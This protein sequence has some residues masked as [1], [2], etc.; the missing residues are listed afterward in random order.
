MRRC[1]SPPKTGS[2]AS[3]I[4]ENFIKGYK[5]IEGVH[6]RLNALDK[7]GLITHPQ[8]GKWPGLKRYADA[9]SGNFPQNIILEPTGFT[10]YNKGKEY[11]GYATQKPPA[12]YEIFIKASSNEGDIVLDPFCGCGTTLVVSE[13]FNR[14]WVGIDIWDNAEKIVLGLFERHGLIAKSKRIGFS[15]VQQQLF[16]KD[17]TWTSNLP[18]RTDKGEEAVPFLKTK[19]K[20]DEPKGPKMTRAEMLEI[21]LKQHGSRCQGCNRQ[22][23]DPRYLELDH[24]APRS[25]GGINHISNRIL[26]CGPCNK[27]KSNKF[28]LSGLIKENKRLGYYKVYI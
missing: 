27:L 23:D 21:L 13:K 15:G 24:N 10:N 25:D 26:L 11:V 14:Q 5:K 17:I 20:V 6:E 16:R 22:F 19:L 28:A 8:R 12:L 18:V 7:A 3:Y 2:Y 1:W 9:D 4:E